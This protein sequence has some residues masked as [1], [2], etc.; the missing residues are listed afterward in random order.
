ME[1]KRVENKEVEPIKSEKRVSKTLEAARRLKGSII[2]LDP[3][4]FL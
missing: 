4:L 3:K 1:K 2:V